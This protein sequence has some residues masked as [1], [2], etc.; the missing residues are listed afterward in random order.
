MLRARRH[1]EIAVPPLAPI[2]FFFIL[3]RSM[4]SRI[5]RGHFVL[6]RERQILVKMFYETQVARISFFK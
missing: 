5:E 3:Q 6:E 4:F 1:A 2:D